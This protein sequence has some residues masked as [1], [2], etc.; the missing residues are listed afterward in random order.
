MKPFRLRK[1]TQYR[2]PW[3]DQNQFQLLI[4]G[5][6]F[7]PAMLAAITGAQQ[8][9]WLEQY[10]VESGELADRFIAALCAAAQR[11]IQ[12]CALFDDYG[13]HNLSE[14]DRSRLLQSGV[15]LQFYNPVYLRRGLRRNFYRDHRKILIVDNDVAF[16][17][18]A[19]LTDEFLSTDDHVSWHDVMLACRGPVVADWQ[20]A[21]AEVW[22]EYNPLPLQTAS[23]MDCPPAGE[24]R[25]RVLLA[26]G[27][28]DQGIL[29]GL[30]Q[31]M[32]RAERRIWIASPYFVTTW[33][34]RRMLRKAAR[35]GLDVRLLLPGS[36]SDHPWVNSAVQRHYTHLLQ[37]GVRIYE[38]L[39]RFIHAKIELC[40]DWVSIGSSNLDR[41]NR[42]WNIE[43]NQ[44]ID[45]PAFA[46]QVQQLFLQDFGLSREIFL[47]DWRRRGWRQRLC[48]WLAS[49]LIY[50]LEWY[51]RRR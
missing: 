20:Q 19:G 39:P 46:H 31:H 13:S 36:H 7:I 50:I 14:A 15:H 43:G 48:E 9:I 51:A 41:W 11:D 1:A 24:Q 3:R 47:H 34:I 32:Q 18:G 42:Y 6:E 21:Y 17:G 38:Y 22:S 10:L 35:Q 26:Q 4:D 27:T 5:K 25:G 37:N 33:K 44:A 28:H 30:L 16:V 49:L 40:D 23:E 2:F 12:V 8:R 45:D 29:R